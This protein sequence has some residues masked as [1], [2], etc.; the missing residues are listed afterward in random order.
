MNVDVVINW[1]Q[2][3]FL[4]L[5]K[6]GVHFSIL[7]EILN[8]LTL[9]FSICVPRIISFKVLFLLNAA[10]GCLWISSRSFLLV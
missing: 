1:L 3:T 10:M 5:D 6:E 2:H 8:F 7:E 9:S 4:T